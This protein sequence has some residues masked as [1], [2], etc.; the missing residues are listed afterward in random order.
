[1]RS[2]RRDVEMRR[3]LWRVLEVCF[4]LAFIIGFALLLGY[5]MKYILPFVIGWVVAILLIPI[6]RW[7][8]RMGVTRLVAVIVTLCCT[9]AA[10]IAVTLGVS[11]GVT[12]EAG[13]FMMNSQ[14]FF[15]YADTFVRNKL[16]AGKV[17]Y[18]QMPPQVANQIQHALVQF[19]T[20]IEQ[21]I[22]SF[23]RSLIG[24]LTQI[25]ELLFVGVI[26]VVT[27]FFIMLRHE[28]MMVSFLRVVPPGWDNK[29]RAILDDMSRAFLGTIRV[30]FILMCMSAVLGVAGMLILHVHYAVLLGILFGLSGLIPILGSAILTV[31]WAIGALV[32]G[33]VPLAIKVLGLQV[34]IS[35]IRHMV[36]PK[37]LAN[38]V[39]LDTLTTLFAL[40]V[41][42]K[43]IGIIG[44]FIGPIIL[45]GAKGLLRTH[46]FVDFLPKFSQAEDDPGGG[47]SG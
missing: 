9:V 35:L 46:L 2:K 23:V 29:I 40:Y 47:E 26:A 43:V 22:R 41:G 7:L 36:E 13:S 12:R 28:K 33:D 45:I 25:P 19:G 37:I 4:L 32:I 21:S 10:A 38:S 30:Q 44:L 17:F 8:E 1:M 16:M 3:Y 6:T 24:A 27:A 18:G 31:P 5:L 20:S 39:G 34:V 11:I 15:T 42:L 14:S